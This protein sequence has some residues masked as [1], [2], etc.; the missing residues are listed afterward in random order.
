M[1][2]MRAYL[3][4]HF[5]V[6]LDTPVGTNVIPVDETLLALVR[7]GI[8]QPC[9]EGRE[10]EFSRDIHYLLMVIR[11]NLFNISQSTQFFNL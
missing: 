7:L 10:N 5:L 4:D 2:V 8:G 6:T 11:T 9:G 3:S 1:S